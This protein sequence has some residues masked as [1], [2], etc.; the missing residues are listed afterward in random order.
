MHNRPVPQVFLRHNPWSARLD[1]GVVMQYL[2]TAASKGEELLQKWIDQGDAPEDAAFA[3][4]MLDPT[5]PYSTL[6]FDE[7]VIAAILLGD[8]ATANGYLSNAAAKAAAHDRHGRANGNLI[9]RASYALG[10]S[11]FAWGHSAQYGPA[12]SAGSGLSQVQDHELALC[13]LTSVM[14]AVHTAT[15]QWLEERRRVGDGHSWFNEKNLPGE[16]SLDLRDGTWSTP[17]LS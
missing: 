8:Q 16:Y 2:L 7:R 10:D 1:D 11:D 14:D 3:Q 4:V 5:R 9:E 12:V 15:T 17:I 6:F 13:M